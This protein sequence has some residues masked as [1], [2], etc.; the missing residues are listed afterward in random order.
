[1]WTDVLPLVEEVWADDE[2]AA[3]AYVEAARDLIASL[4]TP[5][6]EWRAGWITEVAKAVEASEPAVTRDDLWELIVATADDGKQRAFD[7]RTESGE[8]LEDL[9]DR[10][11]ADHR[12]ARGQR[13]EA[14]VAVD[15]E[16]PDRRRSAADI[17]G[18]AAR[19]RTAALPVCKAAVPG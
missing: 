19:S 9:R 6:T 7:T 17:R 15:L 10:T 13:D 14:R 16:Q 18:R 8:R 5:W 12:G 1:V 11:R 4:G 3:G 2:P